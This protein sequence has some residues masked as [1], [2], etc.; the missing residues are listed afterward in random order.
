M[1]LKLRRPGKIESKAMSYELQSYNFHKIRKARLKMAKLTSAS[2][3]L[4]I[5]VLII[6]L[7]GAYV[8]N[9]TRNAPVVR[10]DSSYAQEGCTYYIAPNGSD[11][12]AGTYASPWATIMF[13]SARLVPGD[14]LCAKGGTYTGQGG[15]APDGSLL[16]KAPAANE[17]APITFRNAPGETP[18][19]DGTNTYGEFMILWSSSIKYVIFDGLTVT[20]YANEYGNGAFAIRDTSNVTIRNCRFIDNGSAEPEWHDHHIYISYGSQSN[21]NMLIENNY[22]SGDN[23]SQITSGGK[24]GSPP[25][26]D[27]LR[28]TNNTFIVKPQNDWFLELDGAKNVEIDHNIMYGPTQHNPIALANYQGGAV[29]SVLIHHNIITTTQN[30]PIYTVANTATN[31]S[32]DYNMYWNYITATTIE[33]VPAYSAQ[34]T[35]MRG[36]HSVTANPL[37]TNPPTDFTLLPSSPALALGAGITSQPTVPSPTPTPSTTPTPTTTPTPRPST[38][39]TPTTTPT[40]RPS[41][42]PTSTALVRVTIPSTY[43]RIGSKAYDLAARSVSLTV[44]VTGTAPNLTATINGSATPITSG[45]LSLPNANGDYKVI[46]KDST[47]TYF[48]QTIRIRHPDYNRDNTVNITDLNLLNSRIGKPYRAA[49]TIYDLNLD[50]KLDATDVA[51][52]QA[53][54]GK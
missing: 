42:T 31:V 14:I 3:L 13:A 12:G 47:R 17:S 51:K 25:A 33:G 15:Y 35:I 30:S 18:V 24:D 26:V 52:L 53:G 19:F 40:P 36:G 9:A 2:K 27:G 38:T 8:F 21:T 10:L 39:P 49:Y 29:D 1:R 43:P 11:A 44:S 28:I 5:V 54:W 41:T 22:F 16:W 23:G 7:G 48:S 34:G 45:K 4:S 50:G 32:E 20:H 46:I 37:F 6:A